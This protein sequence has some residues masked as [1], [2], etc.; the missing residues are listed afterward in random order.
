MSVRKG[1][2]WGGPAPLPDN[3]IVAGT[4]RE[5]A[6]VVA[7]H[8]RAN[9]PP[10]PILLTGGDLARTL[11]GGRATS[12]ERTH[13]RV[14]LGAVLVD[15]RLHWF[16]AHLIA[17]R[18]WL[19]G[20]IVMAANAAFLGDWNVAPRAHPGDGR[21]HLIDADPSFGDRLEARRRLRTGTHLPHPAISVRRVSAA[22]IDLDR[23]T[24]IRLDGHSIGNARSLSIR[25]EPEAVEVWI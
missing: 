10:P 19:R 9:T 15:G 8:R 11:G 6:D 18:S 13:V 14:D 22:Q 2:D 4:D 16:L 17:R 5:A 3:A 23:P 21:L 12:S 20:R 25:V 1:E 7:D 24:P